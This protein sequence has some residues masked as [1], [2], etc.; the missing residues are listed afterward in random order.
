MASRRRLLDLHAEARWAERD[1]A[2]YWRE[3]KR[4]HGPAAGIRIADE[5]RRQAIAA[6]PGWPSPRDRAEDYAAHL[7]LLDALAKAS[8]RRR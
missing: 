1:K 3:Y 4:R 5:L 2:L 7:R 8:A 6:R